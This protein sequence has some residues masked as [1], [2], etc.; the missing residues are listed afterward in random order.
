MQ[1]HLFP[2]RIL[3][4]DRGTIDGAAYWPEHRGDFFRHMRTSIDRELSRYDAVVFFESAAVSG[5]SIEGGNPVRTES[6]EEARQLDRS[7]H[8]LWC[9][10]PRFVF[11]PHDPSFIH[12][13]MA[14]LGVM[15]SLIGE[16][17]L[18][19]SKG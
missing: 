2:N 17:Q 4:C 19:P 8:R 1:S 18:T 10:H 14:A 13:T 9:R 15:Q 3:L 7:L 5:L 11:V 12:K 6:L 16:L